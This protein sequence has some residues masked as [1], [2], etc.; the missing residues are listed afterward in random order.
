MGMII[1]CPYFKRERKKSITCEDTIRHYVTKAEKNAVLKTYCS[2]EWRS[3]PYASAMESIWALDLPEDQIKEKIM[4]N[5]IEAMKKE[6]NNL[7]RENGQL[8]S[9]IDKLKKDVEWRDEVG[10]SNYDMYRESLEKKDAL[11]RSKDSYI[12]WIE[13]FASAFLLI[14]YGKDNKVI[15]LTQ[16]EVLTMMTHYNLKCSTDP[17]TGDWIFEISHKE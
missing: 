1:L 14:S 11:L 15:R 16:E 9:R 12:K 8:M 6:I 7:M 4:E 13:S 5:T 2:A 10:K 3:C 17:K